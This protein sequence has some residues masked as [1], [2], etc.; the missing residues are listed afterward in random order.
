MAKKTIYMVQPSSC[1][2]DVMP[3]PYAIAVLHAYALSNEDIVQEFNFAD[4]IFEKKPLDEVVAAMQE[5]YAVFFSCYIWNYEY[6]KA[7]AAAIRQ[8]F[9]LAFLVFG[10]HNVPMDYIRAFVDLPFADYIMIGEGELLF[11]DLLLFFA[12][13]KP[14]DRLYNIAFRSESGALECSMDLNYITDRFVSPYQLGLFD[15][16][17]EKN[18]EKYRFSATLETNRGCPFSCAYCDWGLNKARVRFAPEEQILGDIAWIVSHAIY[19]CYG[20]DSNFGMFPRDARFVEAFC[21]HKKTSGYPK[22][23]FVSFNKNSDMNVLTISE[24]LHHADML[25]GATLSFQ[26]LNPDTLEAIGRK[27]LD[28]GY[29][30]DMMKEYH[31]RHVPTYSELI[32]GLPLETQESFMNGI[33]TLIACG[34]HVA[35]DVYECCVLPNSDLGQPKSLKKYGILTQRLPFRRF[36]VRQNEEVQEYSNIIVGTSTMSKQDWRDCNIFFNVVSAFHFGKLFHCIALYL[37]MEHDLSYDCIYN[38]V[39]HH[40]KSNQGSVWQELFQRM[41]TQLDAIANG[42]GSWLFGWEEQHLSATSFRDAIMK[43]V[44]KHY[45]DYLKQLEELVVLYSDSPDFAKQLVRF[46]AFC[47]KTR[48]DRN[49]AREEVFQ[50]NFS[51]YFSAL[52]VGEDATLLQG[53]YHLTGDD[54]LRS[55]VAE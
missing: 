28:L 42:N 10:G 24:A 47:I 23:F 37:H 38:S 12:G 43:V 19:D 40:L 55:I 26:S 18:R 35:V 13:K 2:T 31:K 22:T 7:L 48:I 50:Y 16:L 25:Q 53:W 4:Y 41:E 5:P 36:D 30:S 20:A 49:L 1:H 51:D 46:Q 29:F 17:V 39:I 11:E 8:R 21:N 33:G 34:Q 44:I 6:N 27:N 15:D 3:L 14:A 52:F 54:I 32:L 9:P 45:T